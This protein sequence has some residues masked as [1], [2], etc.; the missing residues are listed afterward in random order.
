MLTEYLLMILVQRTILHSDVIMMS[1]PLE[2]THFVVRTVPHTVLV[3][4]IHHAGELHETAR[5]HHHQSWLGV[6]DEK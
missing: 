3:V 5:L 6:N 4:I 2:V 1:L